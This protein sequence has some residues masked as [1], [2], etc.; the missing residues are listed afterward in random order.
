MDNFYNVQTSYSFKVLKVIFH[1]TNISKTG[2]MKIN[3]KKSI[4]RK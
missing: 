4:V 2:D 1:S 3:E